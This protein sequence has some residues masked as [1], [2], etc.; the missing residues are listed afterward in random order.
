MPQQNMK[1]KS[2]TMRPTM[3]RLNGVRR[4]LGDERMAI[5]RKPVHE[6]ATKLT[7][8]RN[9]HIS[10]SSLSLGA[11]RKTSYLERFVDG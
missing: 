4:A 6:A 2:G 9:L 3:Y 10:C 11:R 5:I 7:P 1:T 8:L